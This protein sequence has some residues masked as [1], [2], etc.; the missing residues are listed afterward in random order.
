MQSD[1]WLILI[2]KIK[3]WKPLHFKS[4]SIIFHYLALNADYLPLDQQWSKLSS[5][6]CTC[7]EIFSVE[8]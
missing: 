3:G 2:F 4:V 6:S 5:S 1:V 8:C 7:Y